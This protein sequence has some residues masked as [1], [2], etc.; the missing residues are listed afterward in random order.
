[1]NLCNATKSDLFSFS[2]KRLGKV[3]TSQI[4][5]REEK[6]FAIIKGKKKGAKLVKGIGQS[7]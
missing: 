3:N 4:I 2:T 6:C 7:K 1:M 5:I